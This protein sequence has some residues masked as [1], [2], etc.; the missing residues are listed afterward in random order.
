MMVDSVAVVVAECLA[1]RSADNRCQ[2]RN[3]MHLL[4]HLPSLQHRLR[5]VL[6]LNNQSI[7]GWVPTVLV[8]EMEACVEQWICARNHVEA[9]VG[10]NR[11]GFTK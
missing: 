8:V 5:I 11:N 10:F 9:V 2:P 7:L 1:V 3:S 4:E 6:R